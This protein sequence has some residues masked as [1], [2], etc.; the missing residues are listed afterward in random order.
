MSEN[1]QFSL[2]PLFHWVQRYSSIP[3]AIRIY[4]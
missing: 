4:H 3:P 1:Y 2:S